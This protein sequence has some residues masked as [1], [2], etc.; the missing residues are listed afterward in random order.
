MSETLFKIFRP[1]EW[2]DFREAGVFAG[3]A[4]DL[5]DGYIH[6]SGGAQL[7]RTLT[8]HFAQDA[9]VVV[10]EIDASRLNGTLRW[11]SAADGT[12][13]PHLYAPLRVAAVVRAVRYVRGA[14]GLQAAE[15]VAP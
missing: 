15:A 1:K 4:H 14:D 10:A 11:E 13:F 9:S 2:W 5:R 7:G 8:K 6:L 3:S 12:P